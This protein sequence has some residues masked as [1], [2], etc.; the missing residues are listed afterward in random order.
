MRPEQ[1]VVNGKMLSPVYRPQDLAPGKFFV[2][3]PS[4]EPYF[5]YLVPFEGEPDRELH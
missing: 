4:K 5:V 2:E 1:F 3:G